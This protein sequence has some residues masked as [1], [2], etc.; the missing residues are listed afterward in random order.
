MAPNCQR[1]KCSTVVAILPSDEML[2]LQLFPFDMVLSS[3]FERG[4]YGLTPTADDEN[5]RHFTTSALDEKIAELFCCSSSIEQ[6][7]TVC[8]LFHLFQDRVTYAVRPL[9]TVMLD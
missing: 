8:N 9:L 3:E 5:P 2:S 6:G 1:P 4:F 7:V